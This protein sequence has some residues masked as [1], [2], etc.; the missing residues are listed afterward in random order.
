[1]AVETSCDETAAAVI[2]EN[3]GQPVVLSSIVSSQID[4]HQ[5]TGGVVPEVASRAHLEAIIP[6]I[7]EALLQINPKK[8]DTIRQLSGQ[9]L[10]FTLNSK[11]EIEN[12]LKEITHIAVTNGPG[13]VGALLI[14]YNTAKTLAYLKNIPLIPI[15]HIE[16]HIYSAL[17]NKIKSQKSK[18]KS[19]GVDFPIISLTVSGGHTSLTLVTGHGRYQ[20]LGQTRDDAAG[21]AFD[22]VA[23]LL[24]LGYPGG[25]AVSKLAEKFR[26]SKNQAKITFPRPMINDKSFDFSFSG[27]KTAVIN[28]AKRRLLNLENERFRKKETSIDDLQL[29]TDDKKEVCFAFE[30][31]V[32]DLLA[33]KTLRAAKK[34]QPKGIILAGGVSANQRLQEEFKT[35]IEDYNKQTDIKNRLDYYLPPRDMTGDNAAMIGLAAYYR[36]KKQLINHLVNRVDSNLKL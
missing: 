20:T 3:N 4:L 1:M 28:E 35:R 8:Q 30:E 16:G 6:V 17:L 18:V 10:K 22:K 7:S 24:G 32:V 21:E 27:L 11:L 23:K 33:T 36:I 34:Y 12:Y 26:E 9:N 5:K 29:T 31:A 15:N 13:L 14:G 2:S 25:P 19:N